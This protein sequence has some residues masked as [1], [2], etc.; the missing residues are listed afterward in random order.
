[1]PFMQPHYTD[2]PFAE[3]ENEY[4]EGLCVPA[5]VAHYQEGYH[6]VEQHF[7]KIFCRLSANGYMDCTDW[8]GPF[9]TL[10]E[11]RQHIEDTF[12][13]DATTGEELS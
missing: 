10:A 7:G 9:D 3:L 11:A 12:D 5:D 2:E 1:M 8:C 13:V 4:G 6:I